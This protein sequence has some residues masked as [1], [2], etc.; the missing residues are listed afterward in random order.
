M[1]YCTSMHAMRSFLSL[2]CLFVVNCSNAQAPVELAGQ[3]FCVP[4][5]H[6]V[7]EVPWVKP[8]GRSV[9]ESNG[10]AISNCLTSRLPS[11]S[12]SKS[13]CL[14]SSEV[15]TVGVDEDDGF[16]SGLGS[17]G[18]EESVV[19]RMVIAGD[20]THTI[21]DGGRLL[22]TA[23]PRIWRDQYVWRRNEGLFTFGGKPT[24]GKDELLVSCNETKTRIGAPAGKFRPIVACNRELVVNGLAIS[25]SFELA[26]KVPSLDAVSRLDQK[27]ADGLD[28]IRCD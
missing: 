2:G 22:V 18:Y 4:E 12:L 14:F 7:P 11:G 23:N 17:A 13:E 1:V 19:G 21:A 9:R 5:R 8:D 28:K 6:V 10:V 16:R 15:G 20:S 3:R 25:Y 24:A 27:I 26:D